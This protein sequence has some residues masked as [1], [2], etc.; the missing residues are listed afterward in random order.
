DDIEL[1][2]D[3]PA[4]GPKHNG[5]GAEPRRRRMV[6]TVFGLCTWIKSKKLRDS[7][8]FSEQIKTV[9]MR[10]RDTRL[11]GRSGSSQ[12]IL[13]NP[14][15]EELIVEILRAIDSP[16]DVRTLRQLVLSKIP[17]QD[18]NNASLDEERRANNAGDTLQREAVH[19]RDTPEDALLRW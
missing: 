16:A 17:L 5:N 1:L 6:N 11:V 18:Y 12:L 13:S 7:G 15:L 9:P 10:S 3:S 19:V 2:A 14:D 4:E 8:H